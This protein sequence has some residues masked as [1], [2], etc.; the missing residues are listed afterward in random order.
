MELLTVRRVLIVSAAL[1]LCLLYSFLAR[2][3]GQLDRVLA[4]RSLARHEW[5]SAA[6]R[7]D[8]LRRGDIG[9]RAGRHVNLNLARCLMELGDAESALECLD[10]LKDDFEESRKVARACE[11]FTLRGWA[12]RETGAR[13]EAIRSLQKA[14]AIDSKDPLA[15]YLMGRECMEKDDLK[16]AADFFTALAGNPE[17]ADRLAEFKRR[18]EE[19]ILDIP[20][21]E[22]SDV[23]EQIPPPTAPVEAAE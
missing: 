8:R 22:L 20:E 5:A 16:I 6:K 2:G 4:D 21:E 12:L 1:F 19:E 10:P 15:N 18:V 23:P 11:Y 7:Y 17:Y 9:K 3:R 13:D 14:R